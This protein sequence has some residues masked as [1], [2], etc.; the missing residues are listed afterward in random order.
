MEL[1]KVWD[2]YGTVPHPKASCGVSNNDRAIVM[3]LV[4]VV[5]GCCGERKVKPR[6]KG[7]VALT[8]G[9]NVESSCLQLCQ[10]AQH[11]R[12][13]GQIPPKWY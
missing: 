11:R 5:V 6:T 13:E 10:Q 12:L 9:R 4:F 1:C 8:K 7:S 3:L 2:L